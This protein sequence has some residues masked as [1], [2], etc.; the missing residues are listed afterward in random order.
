M[1]WHHGC[2]HDCSHPI[3]LATQALAEAANAGAAQPAELQA[4]VAALQQH[5]CSASSL[6]IQQALA[7]ANKE[8]SVAALL[9]AVRRAATAAAAADSDDHAAAA[10]VV[11]SCLRMLRLLMQLPDCRAAFLA[12][13]GAELLQELL[14]QA[15]AGLTA[16]AAPEGQRWQLYQTAAAVAAL[17]EAAAWQDEDTKC[18]CMDIGL[19]A[20]LVQL[21]AHIGDSSDGTA[22]VAAANGQPEPKQQQQQ[23]AAIVAAGAAAGALRAFTTADDERPPASKAFMHARLLAGQPSHALQALLP[24]LRQLAAGPERQQGPLIAVLGAVRQVRRGGRACS[25]GSSSRGGSGSCG[26]D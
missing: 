23:Q 17:A 10:A 18:R 4:A 8:G 19:A 14:K 26:A 11:V 7:V 24:M 15:Y 25:S 9:A 13:G 3:T 16:A 6:D 2:D 22:A 1:C 21:L 5:F 12:A 20:D